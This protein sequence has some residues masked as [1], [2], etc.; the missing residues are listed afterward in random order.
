[1][2]KA[3][4]QMEPVQPPQYDIENFIDDVM[5]RAR[6]LVAQLYPL[7]RAQLPHVWNRLIE[8]IEHERDGK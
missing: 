4:V 1:M 3:K 7:H 5:D 2:P 8:E 6:H